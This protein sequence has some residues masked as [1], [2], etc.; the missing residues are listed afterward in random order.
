MKKILL[1]LLIGFSSVV[2]A[3]TYYVA[4]TTATPAGKNTN[5]GTKAAP[6]ATFPYAIGR[7]YPGDTV[8]FRGGIYPVSA[9][10]YLNTAY[11]RSGTRKNPIYY[12][13]YRDEVPI[14]D[15]STHPSTNGQVFGLYVQNVSYI[16]FRG[17]IFRN[18]TQKQNNDQ[19]NGFGAIDCNQITFERCVT[20]NNGGHGFSSYNC[21]TIYFKNCDSYNNC[22]ALQ[23][24]YPGGTADGFTSATDGYR[25]HGLISYYGCRAWHNSDD[26]F[27]DVSDEYVVYDHCWAWNNGILSGD[28]NGFKPGWMFA[29]VNPV[30]RRIVNCLSVYNRAIGFHENSFPPQARMNMQV[31]N[32]TAYKNGVWGFCSRIGP[33]S[34]YLENQNIY[35]N[36][37]AYAN[38]PT[39]YSVEY[40]E[41][42]VH[43]HNTW[44][45]PIAVTDADFI[46]VDSTGISGQRQPDGSLPN[47]NFLKLSSTSK[48]ID[49]GIG[50]GLLPAGETP[51][52]GAF[53]YLAQNSKL[54]TS[55]TV[56]GAG[57]VTTITTN[58]GTLQLSTTVLPSDA[59]NKA[60]T[61]SVAN[62]TGQATISSSGLVTAQGNG[63]VTARAT[64]NDGSGVYGTLV[65]TITNQAVLVTS[66]TVT[67]AGGA[68]TITTD[69]GTLQ[70]SA[71]ILP[72]NATNKT[73]AWSITSGSTLASI[74][75]STGLVTAIDNGTVTVRATANDGSGIYGTF[76]I[77][78][79]N[80]VVTV[81]GITVT[82]AG[83]ATTI[84]TDNGTLQ[85]SAAILPSNATN[86]SVTWS[87]TSGSSLASINAST[88]LV[89]A[90][91]NGAVTVRA[92]ANDGSGVYGTF[93]I[94]ISNQV[95]L[96]T[97]ITVTGAG[98]ATTITTDNGTLQ[99]SAAI[100]PSNATNK[101]ITWSITNG[102]TLA[103]INTSTGLVTAIDNGAVTVRA[104]AN[105]GSGVYGTLAITISNQVIHVSSITVTGAGGATTIF[106][107]N[108]TLQLNTAILPS[109]SSNKTITWSVTNNTG[110]ATI[111]QSGLVTAIAVGTVTAR[112]TANDGSGVYGT[113]VITISNQIIAV[114]SI[115]VTGAGGAT[116][117]TT[118]GGSL[119][120]SAAIL[121][122]NATNKAVTWSITSGSSLASIN[123]STGLLNAIDNGSITVR[124]TAND[125][126]GVY[127]TL[128]ITVS[129]QIIAVTSITVTGAGG[130]TAI[131]TNGGSL[132]LSAGILPSNA[133]NNTV[134]WSVTSGANLA[135][136]NGST[137][138]VTAE[139]NGIVTVRATANDGS[140][141][142][143]VL[144]ITISNQV[145]PVTGIT[146]SGA[147][148]ATAITING[149]S[150]QLSAAILPLNA[151]NNTVTWSIT[152]GSNLASVNAS[153]GLVTASDNGA[154]TVRATANDGSGIY[155]TLVIS[156]TNQINENTE[157]DP[158]VIVVNYKSSSYS[159]FVS[160]IDA[161][162]SYD[163]NRDNL[164]FTWITPNNVPVSSTSSSTIK[165]LSPVIN[166][167][168]TVEFTLR[169]SD[170]KTTQSKVIPVEILPYKPYLEVAEISN[171]EASSFQ[172]PYYPY[173]IIDGNIGT[174]WSSDG[175]NQWLIIELKRSFSVQHVK[176]AFQPGQKRESYFDILGSKDKVTWEPI[177]TKVASCAFSGDLQVFEF[178]PSK[179]GEE[180]NYVKLV[181]RCNS[182]DTWNYISE[183]KI[184]GSSHRNSPNYEKLAVKVYPNPAK[185]FVTVRIDESTLVPEFIQIVDLSGTLVFRSEMNPDVR[186]L[187]IPIDLK[188]GVY[189]LQLGSG[190][191]T[192]FTQKLIVRR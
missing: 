161:S 58:K 70:L 28:G 84:T 141:V 87:I 175:D 8:Y 138:L 120:L 43:D 125:G 106:T 53:Q 4:P 89:A 91:D 93:T 72:S 83:G 119:Q 160:E 68:T 23:V 145:F 65:I 45:I 127:G 151:T 50:V 44:D 170:G 38:T 121:P 3:T 66:I 24:G 147:G 155:G 92:T 139:D 110:E 75:A 152:S 167:S 190:K 144:T 148:G 173:N 67:G 153:T 9:H 88:G 76:T 116:A 104:A 156:I 77:T 2:S 172:I 100:L 128:V 107:D 69:N 165:Y 39:D 80:Q 174:M 162:G 146:V 164:T 187:T 85:L 117:I 63:T 5:N 142:Y 169:I 108:G 136:I 62:G 30:G 49:K 183:L 41:Y 112:A 129:N 184:F 103:S 96:V 188:N 180:F 19:A 16:H 149:G 36:N 13:N 82:G 126:S 27:N 71:A 22:D 111:T 11:G 178:P 181:G 15:G 130:A 132:Q 185:A 176:L 150:L 133:T 18:F 14:F 29:D 131:T 135:S 48:L 118:N 177:L 56:T 46:S 6:W 78:I 137:G 1:L 134:T 81:T 171:I 158:P 33:G 109:Y 32:N 191:L 37:V 60:V 182:T 57:G 159:G 154:V 122:S 64:A 115:T 163:T 186:E 99:L 10:I 98:G 20:Y 51:D 166:S 86:K 90:I 12:F 47:L 55:I 7:A 25:A 168:Q 105:D 61:W 79:S 95:V 124:A 21:D 143:G 54:V 73:V 114:T 101:T 97:G 189:V 59:T 74:N 113:L 26:G 123:A 17:L 94:T 31:Y 35:R 140:G 52:L 157:N 40:E 42:W 34:R 192:L 102:S 179:T